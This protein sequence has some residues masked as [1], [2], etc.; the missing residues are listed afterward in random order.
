M[1]QYT[2]TPTAVT[3]A[4]LLMNWILIFTESIKIQPIMCLFIC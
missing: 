3:L 1:Q 2:T 4:N